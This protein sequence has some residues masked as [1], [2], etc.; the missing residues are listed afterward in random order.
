MGFNAEHFSQAE[1]LVDRTKRRDAFFAKLLTARQYP[2]LTEQITALLQ[3]EQ[4][5]ALIEFVGDNKRLPNE[6]W[7]RQYL[8]QPNGPKKKLYADS[9]PWSLGPEAIETNG[10]ICCERCTRKWLDPLEAVRDV[11]CPKDK[12]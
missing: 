6:H 12:T 9:I 2:N 10:P 5:C 11:D 1:R 3:A 7:F 4:A 8:P